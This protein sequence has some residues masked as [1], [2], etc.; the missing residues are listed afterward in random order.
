VEYFK[1]DVSYDEARLVRA[2]LMRKHQ[3]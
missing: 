2:V 3:P 1:G